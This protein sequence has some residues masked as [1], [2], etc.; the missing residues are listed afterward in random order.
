[1]KACAPA[2]LLNEEQERER[3]LLFPRPKYLQE[4]CPPTALIP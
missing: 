4:A 3:T 2:M 1:V